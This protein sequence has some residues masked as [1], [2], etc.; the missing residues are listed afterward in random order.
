MYKNAIIVLKLVL[1]DQ[2]IQLR[3]EIVVFHFRRIENRDGEKNRFLEKKNVAVPDNRNTLKRVRIST[4]TRTAQKYTDGVLAFPRRT[5]VD[6]YQPTNVGETI[7]R[8]SNTTF[9]VN[10]FFTIFDR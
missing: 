4:V 3:L 2:E 6:P 10:I 8:L 9:C 5:V 1:T 7:S